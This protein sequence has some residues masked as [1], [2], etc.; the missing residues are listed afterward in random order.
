M[1]LVAGFTH[2]EIPLESVRVVDIGGEQCVM[3]WGRGLLLR[4]T[5]PDCDLDTLIHHAHELNV[6]RKAALKA[7]RR[8]AR[9]AAKS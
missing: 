9:K 7:A 4:R 8:L 1:K 3:A 2:E 5:H 6:Q